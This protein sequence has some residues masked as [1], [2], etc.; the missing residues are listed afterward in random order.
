MLFLFTLNFN[1]NKPK[2]EG[3][4]NCMTLSRNLVRNYCEKQFFEYSFIF[5]NCMSST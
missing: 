3:R 1:E 5:L 2:R 4:H